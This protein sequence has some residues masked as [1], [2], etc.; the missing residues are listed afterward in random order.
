[1]EVQTT[2]TQLSEAEALVGPLAIIADGL[3][4]DGAPGS[5][6]LIRK[7]VAQIAILEGAR[8]QRD[9]AVALLRRLKQ[10]GIE[11]SAPTLERWVPEIVDFFEKHKAAS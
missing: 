10:L 1:M 5:A 2:P 11:G 7:A 9:E 8:T 6:K 3:T 4:R